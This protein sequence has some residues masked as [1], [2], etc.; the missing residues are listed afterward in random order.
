[1]RKITVSVATGIRKN[2][3]NKYYRTRAEISSIEQLLDCAQWD[4]AGG[5]YKDNQ[6][7][8]QNFISADCVIMDLDNGHSDNEQDWATPEKVSEFFKNVEFSIVYSKSHN[9][10]KYGNNGKVEAGPRPRFHVYFP[11][12]KQITNAD[13]LRSFKEKLLAV[14]PIFDKG[15]KDAARFLFGVE[16]PQGKLFEGTKCIDEFD[17][18]AHEQFTT[19]KAKK[20][21]KLIHE[22]CR[23][24]TLYNFAVSSLMRTIDENKAYEAFIEESTKCSPRLDNDE[25]RKIW[26]SARRADLIECR[27]L[28]VQQI[29][30]NNGDL[31]A[32]R[33]V[34]DEMAGNV[35]LNIRNNAW[36]TALKLS[37]K[38]KKSRKSIGNEQSKAH[39]NTKILEEVLAELKI[40]V[41]HDVILGKAIISDLPQNTGYTGKSYGKLTGVARK[42]SNEYNLPVMLEP[43][44]RDRG[45]KFSTQYLLS[46]LEAITRDNQVNPIAEM[47]T[48]KQWDGVD[49]ISKLYDFLHIDK[50]LYRSF[51]RKW[52]IQAVAMALNDRAAYGNEFVLTLK[53]PQGIGKTEFFRN[54]AM[55]P[56]WFYEGARIDMRDKDSQIKVYSTWITEIG[57]ADSTTKKAQATLKS[58]ITSNQDDFRRPYGRVYIKQARRCCFGATT[59]KEQFLVDTDGGTRRWAVI[60]VTNIEHKTMRTLSYEWYQQ[61]W[62]QAYAAFKENPQGFRLSKDEREEME[63]ENISS[64]DYKPG[65]LEILECLNWR[66]DISDWE[67]T[68]PSRKWHEHR[69]LSKYS[70]KQLGEALTKIKS[71]DPRVKSKHANNGNAYLLP[72]LATEFDAI[73]EAI[74]AEEE[75]RKDIE[76]TQQT[77]QTP[78]YA[79]YKGENDQEYIVRVGLVQFVKDYYNNGRYNYFGSLLE[80][81]EW[82][83]GDCTDITEEEHQENLIILEKIKGMSITAA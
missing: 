46:A 48:E 62:A 11:L 16:N 58:F 60:P 17:F 21:S 42:E 19:T 45:Y 75:A 52:L 37:R 63:R 78:K 6:R 79:K 1:M 44:L 49:R 76:Q 55:K 32:A 40:T 64:T 23:N 69:V 2:K 8:I 15:A 66:A 57:E 67:W 3:A 5:V 43:M 28:A 47:F 25:L 80:F 36:E 10:D 82:N 50:P 77:Q 56:E 12:A 35:S 39:L 29:A 81:A 72:P 18:E 65:E 22:G 27:N 38:T 33:N 24:D 20:S 70:A 53:G 83:A 68:L 41:Q 74:K 31:I 73:N 71:Y 13:E 30:V 26:S 4:N 51:I 14:Y 7:S 54:L 61:L 34:Y 59:N 9:R